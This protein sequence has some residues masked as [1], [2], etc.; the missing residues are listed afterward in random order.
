VG[1]DSQ[2]AFENEVTSVKTRGGKNTQYYKTMDE[3]MD[4]LRLVLTD[5]NE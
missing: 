5:S 4:Y 1:F 2:Q 3:A